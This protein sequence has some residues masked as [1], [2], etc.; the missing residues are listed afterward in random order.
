MSMRKATTNAANETMK[1]TKST[2]PRKEWI[3]LKIIE[4]IEERRKYKNSNTDEYQR[5]YRT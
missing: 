5:R 2:L 4:I 1:E 3:T